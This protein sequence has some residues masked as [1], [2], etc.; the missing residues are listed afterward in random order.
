M[1]DKKRTAQQNR[2]LHLYFTHLSEELNNAGLDMR[3]TLKPEIDIPWNSKTIKEYLW[4]P[5][6]Q[7]Q[8]QKKSTTELNTDEIDLVFNTL[9][10]HLSEKFG[11]TV[12]F[13]S[14]ESLL[15]KENYGKT[16]TN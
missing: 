6:Q 4:R 1:E 15:L 5:I 9:N 11:I 13:P 3:R 16:H 10:R 7:A 8:I 2:A 14:I 12:E